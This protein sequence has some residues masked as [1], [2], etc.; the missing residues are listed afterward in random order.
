[1]EMRSALC[2]AMGFSVVV[3]PSV[4]YATPTDEALA[5]ALFT[6]GKRLFQEGHFSEACSKLA[7]S[8]HLDPAGG[9]AVLLATCLDRDGK[10]ASAWLAYKQALGMAIRDHNGDREAI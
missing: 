3:A 7:E 1:M 10:T 4:A 9:T 5:E 8:Q 2:L 6:A